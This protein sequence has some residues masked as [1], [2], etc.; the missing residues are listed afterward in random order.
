MSRT[1]LG[2][3]ALT[4]AGVVVGII[5]T[6]AHAYRPNLGVTMAIGA[7]LAGAVF[8]RAWLGWLGQGIFAYA[9]L[10]VVLAL[11]WIVGPGNLRAAIQWDVVGAT[12][13]L[14]G[15]IAVVLPAFIPTKYLREESDV[16]AT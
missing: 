5:G 13:I 2:S 7:V 1:I 10:A 11:H 9:W 3:F 12:W 15:A 16:Q 4:L 14:G 8:A 6:S